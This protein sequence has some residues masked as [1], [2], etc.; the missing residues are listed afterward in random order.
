MAHVSTNEYMRALLNQS[1]YFI[2][3]IIGQEDLDKNDGNRPSQEVHGSLHTKL[4]QKMPPFSHTFRH[5]AQNP[6]NK[7]QKYHNPNN[8]ENIS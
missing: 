5:R 2:M 7:H 4:L 1:N 3:H 8:K 6:S